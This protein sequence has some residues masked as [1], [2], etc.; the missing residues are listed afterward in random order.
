MSGA[1]VTRE[2]CA[3]GS[4]YMERGVYGSGD[5]VLMMLLLLDLSTSPT[6]RLLPNS[7]R[8]SSSYVTSS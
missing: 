7:E 5:Q 3:F 4:I 8:Q 1:F 6:S 2:G